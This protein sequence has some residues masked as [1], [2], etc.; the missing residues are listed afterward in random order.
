M[1]TILLQDVTNYISID[2]QIFG[3]DFTMQTVA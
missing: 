1:Y 2:V 3:N